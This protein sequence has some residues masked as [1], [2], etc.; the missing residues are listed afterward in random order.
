VQPFGK[1]LFEFDLSEGLVGV[2]GIGGIEIV[3]PLPLQV[4]SFTFPLVKVPTKPVGENP[5]CD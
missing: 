5:Y 1:L 3:P 4:I 2:T